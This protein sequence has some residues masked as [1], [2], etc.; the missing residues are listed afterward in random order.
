MEQNLLQQL[1]QWHQQEEYEKIIDAVSAIPPQQRSYDLTMHLARALNN[2]DRMEEAAAQL[3]TVRKQGEDDPLWH[4]RMGYALYYMEREEEALEEFRQ[5]CVLDPEDMDSWLFLSW[6]CQT[7]GVEPPLTIPE[8]VL[9][10]LAE[11]E[12]P[13]PEPEVYDEEE[14]AA[15]EEHIQAYFGEFSQVFHELVSPDIH[16]DICIVEPSEERP[17]Y[18]LVT[19]GMGA[20]RMRMPEDL[21][22]SRLERAEVFVCLPPDWKL[23]DPAERWY[24]PIRWLKI[25]ARLP[26]EE[27]SWLGWGHTVPNG[28]PVAENTGFTGVLLLGAQ[29]APEGAAECLLPGGD[30]VVFYQMIPL[31][32]EEMQYKVERGVEALLEKMQDVDHVVDIRRPNVCPQYGHKAFALRREQIHPLLPD[33]DGPQGCIA[34]DR[35]LVDGCKVG[36]LY[37]E[38]P[39]EDFPDSGWRFTAG[40]ETAEYIDDPDHSGI[41]DL[42]TICNYDP[43]IIPLLGAPTGTAF[44]RDET[45]AFHREDLPPEER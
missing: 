21:T 14:M 40:D 10:R 18:T 4:Y 23:T 35:I 15:V 25:L 13:Y 3:E 6:C 20:H 28:G 17:Y 43:E 29:D 19:M 8:E 5:A 11:E 36:Y 38:E 2:D 41:Y 34:T 45:G 31:Y 44:Y 37:R 42:N 22:R 7:L 9:E 32:E 39:E 27:D 1:E 24:W 12:G 26:G 33:W 30:R 16:V